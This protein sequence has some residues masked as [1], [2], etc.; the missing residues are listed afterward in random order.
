MNKVPTLDLSRWKNDK[1]RFAE[2]VSEAYCEFGF[3]CFVNHGATRDVISKGFAAFKALFDLPLE[4]KMSYCVE[5]QAG[6]RGYTPFKKETAKTSS[7]PDLKE[8]WHVGREVAHEDNLYPS[9]LL[10]NL[11]P[12]SD[13]PQFKAHTLGVYEALEEVGRRVLRPMA[14]GL[15]LPEEFFL[16]LT[17]WGNSS[18]RGLHYP[19]ISPID[20]PAVRAAAHEDISFITLLPSATGAGLQLLTKQGDW[21]PIETDDEAIIIN[22][23]DMMQRMTNHKYTSTRQ[24]MRRLLSML[25]I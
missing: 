1:K 23:G 7:H 19:P 24:M 15:G 4:S 3:C 5:G 17:R 9:I 8:F 25:E 14:V 10:D 11:W 16:S 13:I 20:L 6:I 22:V 12:C 21:L 18:L 2:E